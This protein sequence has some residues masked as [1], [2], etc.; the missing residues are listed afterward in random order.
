MSDN[1]DHGAP[2]DSEPVRLR[3]PIGRLILHTTQDFLEMPPRDYWLKGLLAPGELSLIVGPPG[4][5]KSFLALHLGYALA[6]RRRVFGHRVHQCG[7]IYI[8]GE[9]ER[10][11][12][13]RIRALVGKYG[14]A[15]KFFAIAQTADLLHCDAGSGDLASVIQAIRI[16]NAG[17]VIIDTLNRVMAGGDENSPEDM[18]KLITNVSELRQQTGAH[19]SLVHHGTK[20]SNGRDPRGH[21][22]LTGAVDVIL[23]VS[24]AEGGTRR[25]AI[26]KAKDDNDQDAFGFRLRQVQLGLDGDGDPVTTLLVEELD[27]APDAQ[28]KLSPLQRGVYE[29]VAST[30]AGHGSPLPAFP[31][32]P[33]AVRGVHER[34][35]LTECEARRLSTAVAANRRRQSYREALGAIRDAGLIVM[36]EE[37]LWLRQ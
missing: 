2:L 23:E 25:V 22:S 24:K 15:D 34:D 29:A 21:S 20:G 19:V 27:Q 17:L 31:D 28:R 12:A 26:A 14:V 18:G 10:G 6:Q 4:C 8:A 7:V 36:R 1:D 13:S 37:W 5:G 33:P 11:I 3:V 16:A 32:Y 35:I 30:I 9:G